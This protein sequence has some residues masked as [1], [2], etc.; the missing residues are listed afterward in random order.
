MCFGMT[1]LSQYILTHSLTH[2][3]ICL[4]HGA[5]FLHKK[6]TGS[7]S[8]NS[9]YFVEPEHSLPRLQQPVK[10]PYPWSNQSSPSLPIS[11][12]IQLTVFLP[13]TPGSSKRSLS[14]RCP[15]Q[16]VACSFPLPHTCCMSQPS[17][18]SRFDHPNNIW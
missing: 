11:L 3:V 8:R 17:N 4:L 1:Y 16:Q 12:R 7:Q 10:C 14:L 6:L 13:S 15:L 9:P 18:S 2:S 5:E